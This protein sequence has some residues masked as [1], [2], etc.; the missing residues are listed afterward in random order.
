MSLFLLLSHQNSTP[1]LHS[2]RGSTDSKCLPNP[3]E[4]QCVSASSWG[5]TTMAAVCHSPATHRA[6]QSHQAQPKPCCLLCCK[7]A[8]HSQAMALWRL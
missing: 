4:G 6:M 5:C 7:R 2:L 1:T 8:A 3:K